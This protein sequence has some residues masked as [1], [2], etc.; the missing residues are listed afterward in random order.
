MSIF[1]VP[2]P[3]L[4]D[5]PVTDNSALVLGPSTRFTRLSSSASAAGNSASATANYLS[6]GFSVGYV[7]KVQDGIRLLPEIAVESP[8]VVLATSTSTTGDATA[9]ADV[10]VGALLTSVRFNVL[11]GKTK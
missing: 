5:V 6:G 9:E 2:V 10:N 1:S 8:L 7:A 3:V 4:I 11:F